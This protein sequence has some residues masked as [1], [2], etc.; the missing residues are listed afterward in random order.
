MKT[1]RDF[2]WINKTFDYIAYFSEISD[3]N[4]N[5]WAFNVAKIA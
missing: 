1:E 3:K 4:K 5:K 2:P